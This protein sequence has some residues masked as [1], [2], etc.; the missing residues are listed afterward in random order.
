LPSKAAI[1]APLGISSIKI[2]ISF[3][4]DLRL[5]GITGGNYTSISLS[6]VISSANLW[7]PGALK[8]DNCAVGFFGD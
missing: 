5:H 3:N 6:R 8:R 1:W 7:C 4:F 2:N